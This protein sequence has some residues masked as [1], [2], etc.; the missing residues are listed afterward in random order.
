M[1]KAISCIKF[2]QETISFKPGLNVVVGDDLATNSIGKST[3]L[4]VVDFVMGG[5]DFLVHNNDV[6]AE[7]GDH[8]YRAAF[9]FVGES[10]FFR[11]D[12]ATPDVV[13][14]CDKSWKV[15]EAL[16]IQDYRE[17]LTTLYGL[18]DVGLS[19]RQICAPFSRIWGK[20]NLNPA[21]PLD[22]HLK[23]SAA[24]SLYLALK[25]FQKYDEVEDLE[26]ALKSVQNKA[27][28]LNSAFREQ[29]VPRITKRKYNDNS[30]NISELSEE[31]A[32]IRSD[33]ALYATNL[34]QLAN[35]EVAEIKSTKDDLLD[36]RTR[37]AS[38]MQR[39]SIS[40]KE[41]KHIQSKNFEALK[42]FFPSIESEK[43][44]S[45]E[46]FHSDIAKILRKEIQQSK[47]TLSEE[48]DRID[49]T[50]LGLD[51]R[52]REILENVENPELIVDRVYDVSKKVR[53]LQQEN[54]YYDQNVTLRSEAGTLRKALEE[55]R[56]LA[57]S[58]IAKLINEQL[59]SLGKAIYRNSQKSPYLSFSSNN[60]EYKIYEDT[61]TGKAYGNLI[62]FDLAVFTTTRLPFLIHDSL[63]FKNVENKAVERIVEQYKHFDR[64]S[65]IALDEVGKYNEATGKV[66]DQA[67]VVRLSD[68][69]V[70]YIKDWR[71]RGDL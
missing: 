16:T 59:S 4:M 33:L 42:K 8:A 39:V 32:S 34:R 45:V 54:E 63:L 52:L 28:A 11:R 55:K 65:F 13:D 26:G 64:Q 12:T 5:S 69:R 23:Q 62:L 40:L 41:N 20:Q 66:V 35:K 2:S 37:V 6:V 58:R 10:Y 71:R 24:D 44:A 9:D 18:N 68:D 50:L 56:L 46:E 61:G 1:L 7:L 47:R 15:I 19:F 36:A 22:A 31:L 67:A 17:R 30:R 48:L 57:L 51:E 29:V 3:L 25:L 21:R 14:L 43:L 38:R 49:A 70:L 60:Y 27:S 53:S